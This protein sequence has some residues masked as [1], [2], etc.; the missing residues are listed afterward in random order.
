MGIVWFWV[1]SHTQ[2]DRL[3]ASVPIRWATWKSRTK[4]IARWAWLTSSGGRVCGTAP[5]VNLFPRIAAFQRPPC[6][7]GRQQS[8]FSR[9]PRH[10]LTAR[11]GGATEAH[12]HGRGRRRASVLPCLQRFTVASDRGDKRGTSVARKG[13]PKNTGHGVTAPARRFDVLLV[14]GGARASPP[15]RQAPQ[16]VG[17]VPETGLESGLDGALLAYGLGVSNRGGIYVN[18]LGL[19]ATRGLIADHV[20]WTI[21]AMNR[22]LVERATHP[23][24]LRELSETLGGRVWSAGSGSWHRQ[25]PC[26]LAGRAVR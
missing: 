4:G 5:P 12:A 19:E 9:H 14:A 16:C 23:E 17:L 20:T 25:D 8:D 3:V 6:G 26:A 2:Y 10:A 1:G 21:P 22:M 13:K 11:Y 15:R 7:P 18:L 24:M